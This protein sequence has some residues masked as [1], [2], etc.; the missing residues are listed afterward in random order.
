MIVSA[1]I[2]GAVVCVAC[3][4]AQNDAPKQAKEDFENRIFIGQPDGSAMKL[5]VQ[6]RDYRP[7]G[8][9]TWSSDGKMIAFDAWREGFG[10]TKKD[11][12]IIIVNSDG[13]NTK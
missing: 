8:S 4:V 9:P 11:S 13:S 6:M 2:H 7:Q 1:A 12:H 3:L 10:E 5:L